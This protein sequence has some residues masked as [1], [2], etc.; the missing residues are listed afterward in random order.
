MAVNKYRYDRINNNISEYEL[1]EIITHVP[2]P[3]NDDYKRGFIKRYFIQKAN[4]AT[5][6][7]YEIDSLSFLNFKISPFFNVVI[8]RWRISGNSDEI[9]ESNYNSIKIGMKT[10]SSLHLYLPNLLQFCKQ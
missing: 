4:D 1:P 9:K 6:Y 5:G 3:T 7:I 2:T 10:I 8:I